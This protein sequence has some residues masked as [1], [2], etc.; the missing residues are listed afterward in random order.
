MEKINE[1][2]NLIKK[3]KCP[4]KHKIFNSYGCEDYYLDYKRKTKSN[5]TQK[6]YSAIVRDIML[7][8]INKYFL[9]RINIIF[10]YRMGYLSFKQR[11]VKFKHKDN[12]IIP[13]C[14]IDWDKTLKLWIE[15]PELYQKRYL[16]YRTNKE[17]LFINYDKKE[18]S[19]K[20][21]KYYYLQPARKLK[22]LITNKIIIND[23]YNIN[24]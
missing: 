15:E 16:V 19:F 2:I 21:Q 22:K 5:L 13:S 4:R 3:V 20:N 10:P 7:S 14:N 8:L 18:K 24:G 12:K 1:Q 6:E 9:K 11:S 17:N 23:N